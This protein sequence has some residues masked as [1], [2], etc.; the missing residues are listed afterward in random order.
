MSEKED[1]SQCPHIS[2]EIDEATEGYSD[3][4]DGSDNDEQSDIFSDKE[5]EHSSESDGETYKDP[6]KGLYACPFESKEGKLSKFKVG[7]VF[8]DVKAVTEALRDYAV[9]EDMRYIEKKMIT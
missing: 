3:K 6:F 4:E 2:F 1:D 8:N 7:Q 5:D 9:K